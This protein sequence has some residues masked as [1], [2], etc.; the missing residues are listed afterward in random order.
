MADHNYN[1]VMVAAVAA[2]GTGASNVT[3]PLRGLL[4]GFHIAYNAALDAG[5]DVTI[6][7]QTVSGEW[8]T[9]LTISNNKTSGFY[10]LQLA[11]VKTDG[12][13]SGMYSHYALTDEC[14]R[15]TVAQG[16]TQAIANAVRV[17]A[18]IL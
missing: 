15:F 17:I 12:A 5:T 8:V 14:L 6:Q 10:P 3:P 16:G 13:L 4:W 7:V 11:A 2:D 18:K 1:A 9:L